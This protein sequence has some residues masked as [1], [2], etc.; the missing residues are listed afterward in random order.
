LVEAGKDVVILLDSLTRLTRAYNL[1][2]PTSGR[3]LSGGIDP[4]ALYP[5]KKFFGAARNMEEGGSLTIL[6]ACLV[7]TGSRMDD[8]I[9]E[10]FKGTGNMEVHLDRKLAERRMFPSIDIQKSGTRRE[11]LLM[12]EEALKQVWLLRRMLSMADSRSDGN[13]HEVIENLFSRLSKTKNNDEFLSN[14][15]RELV[16]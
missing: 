13:S 6:A 7:E 14:L 2:V 3:T 1:A 8:V 10:E 9:Y 16:K 4:I 11:E 15:G 12:S 5:P